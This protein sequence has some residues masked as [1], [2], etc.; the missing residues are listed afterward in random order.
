MNA[1]ILVSLFCQHIR[2]STNPFTHKGSLA[3]NDLQTKKVFSTRF[4]GGVIMTLLKP[5]CAVKA[6]VPTEIKL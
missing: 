4:N 2:L 1:K 6:K 5:F 3:V